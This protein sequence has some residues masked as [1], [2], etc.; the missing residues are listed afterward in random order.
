MTRRFAVFNHQDKGAMIAAAL[1]QA[2]WQQAETAQECDVLLIDHDGPFAHPRPQFIGEAYEAGAKVV[3]YPHG[4][5]PSV[6]FYDGAFDPDPRVA[7]RLE[8][9]AG[10]L[11]IAHRAGLGDLH[12]R[13]VGWTYTPRA[14][15]APIDR[16]RTILFA[17]IQ[18][19]GNGEIAEYD[20]VTNQQGWDQ[21]QDVDAEIVVRDL[22][23]PGSVLGAWQAV[24]EADLVVAAGSLAYT[25]I[26][27]GKP[28]VM[29][30]DRNWERGAP[31][32]HERLYADYARYP[33]TVGDGPLADLIAEACQGSE[34]VHEWANLFVGGPMVDVAQLLEEV[35]SS[36]AP[37]YPSPAEN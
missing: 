37:T 23:G 35:V 9:G 19:N 27:S 7:V 32:V 13:V 28:V 22:G 17:P 31:P 34:R 3:L 16:P 29:L 2:G 24:A 11:E 5:N 26:A 1:H 33:L 30:H 4:A 20:A 14:D 36:P 8:H 6:T 18:A 12:Q 21:L 15:F 10:P 25:A